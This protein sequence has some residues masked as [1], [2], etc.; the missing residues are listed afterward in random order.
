[1]TSKTVPI[2]IASGRVDRGVNMPTTGNSEL[3]STSTNIT[4]AMLKPTESSVKL[5]LLFE[6]NFRMSRMSAPGTNER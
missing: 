3:T 5:N 1:M 4:K 2:V 6:F